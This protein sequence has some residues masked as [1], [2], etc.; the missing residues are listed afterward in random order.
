MRR[1]SLGI[2]LFAGALLA[3]QPGHAFDARE[4]QVVART[5]DFLVPRLTGR[6]DVAIIYAPTV[7]TSRV[8]AE[9]TGRLIGTG[10]AVANVTLVAHLVPINHLEWLDGM[11]LALVSSGLDQ[12]TDAVF[13]ATRSR[14]LLSIGAE[15]ACVR[16]GRCVMWVEAEP[17]VT[18]LVN[19]AAA[20]QSSLS[21]R[22]V[23]RMMIS[24]L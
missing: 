10:L 22:L 12:A 7:A 13:A 4:L 16:T 5:L 17:Q 18:I 6:V 24:E 1:C 11:D 20:S 3:G 19:T 14:G 9:Q 15:E 21:F 2:G 23:F 8:R